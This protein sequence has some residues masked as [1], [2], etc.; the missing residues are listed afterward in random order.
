M[1]TTIMTAA[2]CVAVSSVPAAGIELGMPLDC[3]IGVTCMIQNYVDAEPGTGAKDFECGPLAYDNHQGTDFRL[4]NRAEIA[5]GYAALATAP[6]K[7]VSVI[8]DQPDHGFGKAQDDPF[9]C[10]NAVMIDHGAGWVSQYCHLAQGSARVTRGQS[11][12]EGDP[13]GLVGSSGGTDFPH[14]HYAIRRFAAVVNP[15]TG[16]SPTGCE[17]PSSAP[18]WRAETGLS[19]A[20]TGVFGFGVSS[21][22]P[23]LDLVKRDH[24]LLAAPEG[25]TDPFYIWLH[26]L[27]VQKGDSARLMAFGPDGH[28]FASEL[29]DVSEDK[30]IYLANIGVEPSDMDAIRWP[31]GEYRARIS[32]YVDGEE[33]LR[34]EVAFD[35]PIPSPEDIAVGGED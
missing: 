12:R 17:A 25:D 5:K 33:A 34:E 21:V 16:V 11:V 27:G 26:L 19:Y 8:D 28:P 22:F 23:S 2:L 15:F 20:P 1:K 32:F 10:G 35:L 24:A 13:L 31:P 30:T 29:F 9:G 14:L 4:R 6:G 7:V 18:L 3:T